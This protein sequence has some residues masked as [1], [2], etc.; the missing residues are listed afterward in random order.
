M[1]DEKTSNLGAPLPHPSNQLSDDVIR[2][3]E[4]FQ[5]VDREIRG[6]VFQRNRI[7]SN[8]TIPTGFNV[9][10]F[11]DFEVAPDVTVTGQGNS[12]FRGL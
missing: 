8:L 2:I 9:V 5:V 1:I 4:A 12:T 6:P 7:D 3:R 11:G 10:M